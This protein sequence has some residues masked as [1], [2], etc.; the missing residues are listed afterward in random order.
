MAARALALDTKAPTI[1]AINSAGVRERD[2]WPGVCARYSRRGVPATVA[3]AGS[4]SSGPSLRADE[5]SE[6]TG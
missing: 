4:I 3:S 6:E 5:T 1:D 2:C